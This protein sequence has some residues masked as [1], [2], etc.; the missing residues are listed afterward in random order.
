MSLPLLLLSTAIYVGVSISALIEKNPGLSI[1][2][3]GYTI[4]N[5]GIIIMTR[6]AA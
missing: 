2:F 5:L 4:G 3:A 6:T 1:M